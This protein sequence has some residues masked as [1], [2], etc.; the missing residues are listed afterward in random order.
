MIRKYL[1]LILFFLQAG[2]SEGY[3]LEV[4]MDTHSLS[5]HAQEVPLQA[6]LKQLAAQGIR[7]QIDPFLN[8][9]I[10]VSFDKQSLETGIRRICK[11]INHV[12]VW[13]SAGSSS[14][15]FRLAEIQIFEPGKESLMK[16]LKNANF[17][18]VRDTRDGSTYIRDEVLLRPGPGISAQDFEKYILKMGGRILE[19]SASTGI[20]RIGLPENSDVPA[21]VKKIGAVS[22]K[23]SAEPNYAYPMPL[24]YKGLQ[25]SGLSDSGLQKNPGPG[26]GV[27]IAILDSGMTSVAGLSEYVVASLDAVNP[28]LPLIDTLGH[29]T[30]MALIASGLVKPLGASTEAEDNP[31]PIIP[32]RAFDDQGF[33]SN[34]SVMRSIDFALKNGA[35]VLSL[36]WGSESPSPFLEKAL[37]EAEAQ[38]LIIVAAAGNRPT[39]KTTW[40]AA[41]PSVIGVGALDQ[42]G[43]PWEQSNYGSFVDIS[44]PGFAYMP[45]GYKE[46]PGPYAGTSISTAYAAHLISR[47]LAV[48]PKASKAEVYQALSQGYK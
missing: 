3:A 29:G 21:W 22:D 7:V 34:F 13:E 25:N 48:H 15:E 23:A 6:V 28:D 8:P 10:S 20:Y 27:P 18:V 12:L 5:V 46:D 16:S 37:A 33:T 45:V 36:S 14:V 4:R 41:Y 9:K 38:N 44:V 40:P 39:G 2:I 47:Y 19:Y 35:G 11:D 24:P 26:K 32:I 17:D 31:T 30:Q 1:I 43:K 42:D